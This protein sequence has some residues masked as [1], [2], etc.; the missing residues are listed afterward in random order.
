MESQIPFDKEPST[1]HD[2]V[3]IKDVIT[4]ETNHV[5]S[6]QPGTQVNSYSSLFNLP[7]LFVNCTF[8]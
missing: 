8:Y 2:D 6:N 7:L 4:S 1:Q 5:A 3:F